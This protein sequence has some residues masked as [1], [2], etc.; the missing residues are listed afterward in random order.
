MRI[1]T[2]TYIADPVFNVLQQGEIVT[3]S[4]DYQ[5]VDSAG[6]ISNPSTVTL[7]ILG[8]ND[9]PVATAIDAG[10]TNEDAGA[11]SVNLLSTTFRSGHR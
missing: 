9:A 8:A 6:A 1:G 3:I 4:F 7:Q 5:A 2:F 10:V 11:I